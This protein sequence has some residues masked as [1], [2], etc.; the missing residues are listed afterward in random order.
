MDKKTFAGKFLSRL[1]KIDRQQIES[2]LLHLIQAR[3][4][5]EIIFNRM[6]EGII[7]TDT[8]YRILFM[9]MAACKALGLRKEPNLY[10][11]KNLPRLIRSPILR[12]HILEFDPSLGEVISREVKIKKPKGRVLRVRF[13]PLGEEGKKYESVVFLISDITEQK[14]AEYSMYQKQRITALAN[15]TAG[16]AHE[17]KNPLNSLQIHAQLLKKYLGRLQEGER[18]ISGETHERSL[19]SINIILEETT[20]LSDIVNEFLSAASPTPLKLSPGN[21]NDTIRHVVEIISPVLQEKG[22]ELDIRLDPSDFEILLN[23]E[24]LSQAFLNILKN[25]SEALEKRTDPRITIMTRFEGKNIAIDFI[26][27]GCGIP[28]KNLEKIF[29]PYFTTKFSG[30]GLGLMLVYRIIREHSGMINVKSREGEGTKI[31]ITIPLTKWP[32]RLLTEHTEQK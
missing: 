28:E 17:I 10:A 2:F 29:E 27:N 13:L 21:V 15:L 14:K 18:D 9:N 24:R 25:A 23:H 7:V 20:R 32:L 6:L 1:E 30:T 11:G 12:E 19:K 5:L 31:T 8:S 22:I 26:D 4:F 16:V 3:D